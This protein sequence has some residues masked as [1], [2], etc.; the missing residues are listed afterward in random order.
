ML[1]KFELFFIHFLKNFLE[2]SFDIKIRIWD[3]SVLLFKLLNRARFEIS[4]HVILR[5]LNNLLT[6]WLGFNFKRFKSIL[7]FW[8]NL[9]WCW[10]LNSISWI[11]LRLLGFDYRW[12]SHW[13]IL[14]LSVFMLWLLLCLWR[15][16]MGYFSLRLIRFDNI[17][18]LMWRSEFLLRF[19]I[20]IWNFINAD[21][22]IIL[23]NSFILF[24]SNDLWLDFILNLAALG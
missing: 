2:F 4:T 13:I 19:S 17:Y 22:W 14:P 8:N 18:F 21:T 23:P 1:I 3:L 9:G 15:T 24:L 6:T 10:C 20:N 5:S 16:N 11:S 7:I 12:L